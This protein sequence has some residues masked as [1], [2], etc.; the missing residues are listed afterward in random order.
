[1]EKNTAPVQPREGA[2]YGTIVYWLLI[3]GVLTAIIGSGLYLA[4]GSASCLDKSA[5]LDYLWRGSKCET[6]WKGL[7]AVNLPLSWGSSL[8]MLSNGD[9]IAMLGIDITA[10]AA[11]LGM[12]GAAIMMMRRKGR[13]HMVFAVVIAVVLTLS[14][15]GVVQLEM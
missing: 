14:V 11:V 4:S 9:M 6:I 8:G 5:L 15:L 13:L 12:W 10:V 1:M 7:G 2:V 3:V